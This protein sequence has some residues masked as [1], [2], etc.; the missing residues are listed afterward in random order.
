MK[1]SIRTFLA[2]IGVYNTEEKCSKNIIYNRFYIAGYQYYKGNKL[3][4]EDEDILQM[5]REKKNKYDSRAISLFFKGMKIGFVPRRENG[6]ISSLLDQDIKI[7][8]HVV[9]VD[10][11]RPTWERVLVELR[12][13]L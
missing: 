10:N 11:S 6:V 5:R 9:H 13:K 1:E 3:K 2:L 7:N 12:G 4:L 8:A